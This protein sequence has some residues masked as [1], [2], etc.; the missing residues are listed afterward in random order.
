VQS[1]FFFSNFLKKLGI[2][3]SLSPKD[4]QDLLL[5]CQ[6]THLFQNPNDIPKIVLES[7]NRT[8][9][10]NCGLLGFNPNDVFTLLVH[11]KFE[12]PIVE[13]L[14][15]QCPQIQALFKQKGSALKKSFINLELSQTDQASFAQKK[16]L[17]I[18]L[19]NENYFLMCLDTKET[20]PTLLKDLDPFIQIL[21]IGLRS[22]NLLERVHRVDH[23]IKS[24]VTVATQELSKTNERLLARIR[25]LKALDQITHTVMDSPTLD[26]LLQ[27]TG[28]QLQDLFSIGVT[29]FLLNT[30]EK[31]SGWNLQARY[32]SLDLPEEIRNR[33]SINSHQHKEYGD[34]L[35]KIGDAYT[36]GEIKIY[37][38]SPVFL[39]DELPT[40]LKN[41]FP[42]DFEKTMIESLVAVPVNH[43]NDPQKKAGV[44]ILLNV[45][46]IS[47]T[48]MQTL[49]IILPRLIHIARN[50]I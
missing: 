27:V 23:R 41:S 35:K 39:K 10:I 33:F 40:S 32:L 46:D 17:A 14:K 18:H 9:N 6:K 30:S 29:G 21:E 16:F 1:N 22:A 5:L 3:R 43:P 20:S 38:G 26:T 50:L 49:D 11:Q 4:F 13:Y 2:S 45:E 44:L 7:I 37:K 31:E 8:F 28:E 25:E 47:E 12:D 24:E 48:L 19:I 34:A 36:T 15:A 42:E